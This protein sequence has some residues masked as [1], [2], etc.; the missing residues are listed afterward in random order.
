[1]TRINRDTIN[2]CTVEGEVVQYIMDIDGTNERR[3]QIPE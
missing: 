1:M 2:E 3:I